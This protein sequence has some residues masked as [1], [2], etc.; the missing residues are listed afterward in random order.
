LQLIELGRVQNYE[1]HTDK[2]KYNTN[3]YENT[4]IVR[5]THSIFYINSD[6]F[7]KELNKLCPLKDIEQDK[8]LVE[9]VFSN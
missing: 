8:T 4:K 1:L 5:P 3:E 9:N 7:R 6:I 2:R